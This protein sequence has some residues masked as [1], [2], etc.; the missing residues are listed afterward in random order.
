MTTT[1]DGSPLE[2]ILAARRAFA[3]RDESFAVEVRG[4]TPKL[5]VRYHKLPTLRIECVLTTNDA[6]KDVRGTVLQTERYAQLVV[7]ATAGEGTWGVL[8]GEDEDHL[9]SL[10]PESS[11]P[12]RFG[13][14]L[15]PLLGEDHPT[16]RASVIAFFG[17]NDGG[18]QE[19]ARHAN[20]IGRR[21]GWG[22]S[23]R[24]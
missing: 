23:P 21:S 17:G 4:Y 11:S 12:P 10:D 16:V 15:D 5:W 1:T 22:S 14:E 13:N 8:T 9:E 3:E 19:L 2:R 7:D 18:A 20:E 24:S 6:F